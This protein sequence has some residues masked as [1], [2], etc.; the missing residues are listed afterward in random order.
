MKIMICGSMIFIKDIIKAKKDLDKLGHKASIPHGTEP[1]QK[2]RTFLDSLDSNMKYC[3]KNN[4]MKRNFDLVAENDAVLV[5]NHRK[6]GID[7][8]IGVSVLMEMAVAHYLNKK[9]FILNNIPHFDDVRWAHEV[10]IM[11]PVILDGDFGK[12]K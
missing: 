9:I 10:A 5:L 2:D 7:G 12:I 3:I 8:Y 4:V 1:H 11:Q 6:N